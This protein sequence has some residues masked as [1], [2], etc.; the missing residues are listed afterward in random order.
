MTQFGINP[1]VD[2]LNNANTVMSA[3]A[4]MH[5][6]DTLQDYGRGEQVMGLASA[7]VL[8]CKAYDIEPS[9]VMAKTNNIMNAAE[10]KRRAEFAAVEMY[11]QLELAV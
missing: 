4:A 8:M 9:A 5:V 7:F 11:M 10:H 6:I 1:V 3:R 2:Q